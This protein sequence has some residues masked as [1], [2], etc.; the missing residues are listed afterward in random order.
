[1]KIAKDFLREAIQLVATK[2]PLI[3]FKI[4]EGVMDKK[5][6]ESRTHKLCMQP[7]EDNSPVYSLIIEVEQVLR[8][9]NMG[10]MDATYTLGVAGSKDFTGYSL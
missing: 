3:M 4:E 10:N 2:R 8:R 6:G 7:E 9:Q 1:M 5:L